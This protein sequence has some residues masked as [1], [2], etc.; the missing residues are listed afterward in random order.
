MDLIFIHNAHFNWGETYANNLFLAPDHR[1]EE[2][3]AMDGYTLIM[4]KRILS[5][6]LIE[7]DRYTILK[8]RDSE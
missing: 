3:R 8:R 4:E 1:T 5:K 7:P 6:S 2:Q